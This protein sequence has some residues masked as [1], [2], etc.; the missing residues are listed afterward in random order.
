[1]AR[2]AT[3]HAEVLVNAA[4]VLFIHQL[5]ALVQFTREVG[6]VAAV[7]VVGRAVGFL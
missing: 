3:V 2:F 4:F 1:M 5:S 6:F 7:V